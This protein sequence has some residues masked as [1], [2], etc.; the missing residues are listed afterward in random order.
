MYCIWNVTASTILSKVHGIEK[1]K[2]KNLCKCTVSCT[3]YL[4]P[5]DKY[6]LIQTSKQ[7]GGND[8]VLTLSNDV[9]N[10]QYAMPKR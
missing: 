10:V 3:Y 2:N 7:L 8:P 9:M 6:L 5:H 1:I 4:V